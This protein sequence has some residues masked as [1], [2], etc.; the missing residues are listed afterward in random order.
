MT[1][2]RDG[3]GQKGYPMLSSSL[4]CQKLPP[5]PFFQ[6]VPLPW[7]THA[8]GSVTP[9]PLAKEWGYLSLGWKILILPC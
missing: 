3:Q 5:P 9:S 2:V 4:A 7:P 6:D 1:G 8:S